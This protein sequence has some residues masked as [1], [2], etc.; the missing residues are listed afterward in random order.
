MILKGI[1]EQIVRTLEENRSFKSIQPNIAVE[2]V[3][4]NDTRAGVGFR[5]SRT[6]SD[7]SDTGIT[8]GTNGTTDGQ[9]IG[10]SIRLP[11]DALGNG[12]GEHKSG[13]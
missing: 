10:S 6:G 7:I 5:I 11:K 8:Y 12:N 13:L 9:D 4:L 2:G 1:G 3:T